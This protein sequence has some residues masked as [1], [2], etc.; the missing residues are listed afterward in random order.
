MCLLQWSYTLHNVPRALCIST[1]A[2]CSTRLLTVHMGAGA[3]AD[4][5]RGWRRCRLIA[6]VSNSCLLK[7]YLEGVRKCTTFTITVGLLLGGAWAIFSFTR[8]QLYITHAH[9][10]H[11]HMICI[12][13][14]IFHIMAA[15]M[16]SSKDDLMRWYPVSVHT[17][18][19]DHCSVRVHKKAIADELKKAKPRN[20]VLLPLRSTFH[21]RRM[22]FQSAAMKVTEILDTV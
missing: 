8:G 15:W 10:M 9:H 12:S 22:F 4:G 19:D 14:R 2:T 1:W 21:E 7:G 6:A 3:G 20:S 18:P 17:T 5:N 11:S 16:A 13:G